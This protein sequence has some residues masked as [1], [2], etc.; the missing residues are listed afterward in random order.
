MPTLN[1][2][3]QFCSHVSSEDTALLLRGMKIRMTANGQLT[4]YTTCSSGAPYSM[5][6]KILRCA[7]LCQ[8][9]D[10]V[11][12]YE[13]ARAPSKACI[14]PKQRGFTKALVLMPLHIRQGVNG[15]FG[16]Q[17]D[18]L[19]SLRAVQ[20]IVHHFRHTRLGGNDKCKIIADVIIAAACSGR[21]DK[22]DAVTFT[23]V[24]D[25]SSYPELGIGSDSRLF[26]VGMMT[27]SLLRNA[28]REPGSFV[29]YRNVPCNLNS[30]SY[31]V[32]VCGITDAYRAVHLV[33]LFI[34][35]QLH[36]DHIA[37]SLVALRRIYARV[38]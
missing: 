34:A 3:S 16:L 13:L 37:A 22:H 18:V 7:L 28:V 27:E 14:T 17:P 35:S 1:T 25:G 30:I 23:K 5:R 24:H 11:D 31:P 21:E 29:L 12:M 6:Y 2:W 20:N 32:L 38:K 4:S 15:K 8:E 9:T 10:N 19:P 33:A 36:H 26:L